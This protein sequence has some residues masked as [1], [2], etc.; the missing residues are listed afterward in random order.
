MTARVFGSPTAQQ[1]SQVHSVEVWQDIF[2]LISFLCILSVLWHLL[3]QR[4]L[5]TQLITM[6]ISKAAMR[7]DLLALAG[8]HSPVTVMCRPH[9]HRALQLPSMR[10]MNGR[11]R[12]RRRA[13]GKRSRELS[14]ATGR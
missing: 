9:T 3:K 4:S 11:A 5:P 13:G 2:T 8:E 12:H 1:L 7:V 10:H 6:L 14:S